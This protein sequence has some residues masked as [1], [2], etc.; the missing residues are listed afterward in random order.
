MKTQTAGL[1]HFRIRIET[2]RDDGKPSKLG[3]WHYQT[4]PAG[5]YD[6]FIARLCEDK[7]VL[8]FVAERLNPEDAKAG[9]ISEMMARVE[10]SMTVCAGG[11][12]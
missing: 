12:R 5:T 4:V 10:E 2:V 6:A 8:S 7:E 9:A 11:A 3:E 1:D